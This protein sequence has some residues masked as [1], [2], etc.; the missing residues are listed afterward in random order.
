M[1]LGRKGGSGSDRRMGL[2]AGSVRN[3]PHASPRTFRVAAR[4][5]SPPPDR[6][7][8]A[9]ARAPNYA[10]TR[11]PSYSR[12]S[13]ERLRTNSDPS[14]DRPAWPTAVPNPPSS[15]PPY[16]PP[17]DVVASSPPPFL[18]GQM[19]IPTI[20]TCPVH[21]R[22][23]HVL[24]K[25]TRRS[26]EWPLGRK[27]SRKPDAD[28]GLPDPARGDRGRTRDRT[29]AEVRAPDPRPRRPHP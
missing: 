11:V 2:G 20:S 13:V 26:Q 10:S 29:L 9:A 22:R 6:I 12:S 27:G 19:R 7:G 25:S 1:W 5:R 16:A 14:C 8:G 15:A 28:P 21:E 24:E 18:T 17:S 4:N 23:P 3:S